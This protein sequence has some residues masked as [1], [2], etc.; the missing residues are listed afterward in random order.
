MNKMPTAFSFPLFSLIKKDDYYEL[1]QCQVTGVGQENH[2]L[3]FGA[4]VL[5]LWWSQHCGASLAGSRP[6]PASISLI[7]GAGLEPEGITDSP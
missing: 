1:I 5:Q 4:V 7:Q 6:G 3:K 2:S